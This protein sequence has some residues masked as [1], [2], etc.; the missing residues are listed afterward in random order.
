M[1]DQVLKIFSIDPEYDLNLIRPEQ[2]LEQVL[3]GVFEHLPPIISKVSPDI[4]IVQ[5]DT[6][7]TFA[8]AKA[9]FCKQIPVGHVEAG[10]R[11]FN[12]Y[13]PFPEEINRRLT[14]VVTDFHFAPTDNNRLNLLREGYPEDKIWITG[15]TVIDALLEVAARE[16]AFEDQSLEN[17]PGRLILVTAHRRESFGEP[18]RQLCTGLKQIAKSHPDDTVIYPVHLNP[19]VRKPVME[20]LKG[21]DNVR[22]IEPLDY[23][24]FVHL[25]K[26]A[27]IV[28]TDSGGI[29]EESPSLGV[30]ALVMRETTERPEGVEA[31]TVKLV[32]TNTEHIVAEASRLLDHPDEHKKMAEANNPYGDGT[33]CKQICDIIAAELPKLKR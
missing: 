17:I 25:L 20:I 2:T 1:L 28:L 3:A 30:P 12:K 21:V 19:N 23:E 9:A 33:S 5:G 4:V 11:T 8:G 14:S 18:F 29:Q 26:K 10:L 27:F 16:Y 32:G 7:T 31:G 24:P 6:T 15:N 13:S 22:L